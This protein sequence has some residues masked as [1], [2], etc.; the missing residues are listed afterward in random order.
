VLVTHDND[1]AARAPRQ[2]R[3]KDGKVSDDTRG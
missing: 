1:V 3:L 2:I